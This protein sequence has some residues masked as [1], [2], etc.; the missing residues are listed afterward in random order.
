V[1]TIEALPAPVVERAEFEH[2]YAK[3]FR[4][5]FLLAR[6]LGCSTDDAHDAVQDAA[7]RAWRYRA[8]RHGPFRPWS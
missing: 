2:E 1:E 4:S 7:L 6:Q 3:T 5:A 8:A